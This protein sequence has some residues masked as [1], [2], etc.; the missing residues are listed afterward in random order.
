MKKEYKSDD[1]DIF[2]FFM[3]V[4]FAALLMLVGVALVKVIWPIVR[5]IAVKA[6][7]QIKKRLNR[8]KVEKTEE[9]EALPT[10]DIF[11]GAKNLARARDLTFH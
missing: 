4:I 11:K 3:S 9:I 2:T 1:S 5:F 6:F 10:P 7:E 8:A